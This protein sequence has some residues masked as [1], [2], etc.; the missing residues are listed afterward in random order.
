MYLAPIYKKY[1]FLREIKKEYKRER[2]GEKRGSK[3]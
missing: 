1:V 3:F 2:E